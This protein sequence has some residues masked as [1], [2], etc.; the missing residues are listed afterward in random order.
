[1]KRK[2]NERGKCMK[3]ELRQLLESC[4]ESGSETELN[5]IKFLLEAVKQKIEQPT[6]N[7]LRNLLQMDI[8]IDNQS[9]EVTIPLRP[10]YNNSL[11]ILHGG[12]TAT[13]LDSAMGI[14]A[15]SLLP[16]GF[17]AVTNQLN[18]HYIAP[19]FGDHLRCRAEVIHQGKQTL[20]IAGEAYRSDGKQIAYATGTFFMIPP[21]KNR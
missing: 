11:Q 13:M 8:K 1:M 15:N 6:S 20:V 4:I 16:D 7:Y 19:G 10:V 9:C 21:K 18:I 12:V 3:D 14:L 5:T 17:E 2:S